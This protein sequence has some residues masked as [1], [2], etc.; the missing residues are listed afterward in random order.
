MSLLHRCLSMSSKARQQL[1]VVVAVVGTTLGIAHAE[2]SQIVDI[3][4]VQICLDDGSGCSA[5]GV[6]TVALQNYWQSN[7][8]ITLNFLSTRTFNSSVLNTVE[9]VGE[10]GAFLTAPASADPLGP[11][12]FSSSPLNFWFST[13]TFGGGQLALVNGNRSWVSTGFSSSLQ[14]VFMAQALGFNLGL[15]TLSSGVAP[16]NLMN[17]VFTFDTEL[18]DLNLLSAQAS[19]AQGSQFLYNAPVSQAPEPA[20]VLLMLSG[21]LGLG[22]LQR[23]KA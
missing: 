5:I 20:G 17:P 10:I 13:G 21:L 8:G 7:A 3:Q 12:N 23:R 11:T 16:N 14:T 4:P 9:S 22:T 2:A 1:A 6:D 15:S 18:A 19:I